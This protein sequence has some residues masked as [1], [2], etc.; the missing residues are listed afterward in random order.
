MYVCA[1][2][3]RDRRAESAMGVASRA[4]QVARPGRA[5]PAGN[6]SR[7]VTA[8]RGSGGLLDALGDTGGQDLN[9]PTLS[10]AGPTWWPRRVT[11]R[12]AAPRRAALNSLRRCVS[13]IH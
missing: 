3:P 9:P 11:P 12:L 8:G 7:L 5:R 2:G 6:P 4:L 1:R 10:A 13:Y